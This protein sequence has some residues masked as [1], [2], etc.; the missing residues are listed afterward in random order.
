MLPSSLRQPLAHQRSLGPPQGVTPKGPRTFI[1]APAPPPCQITLDFLYPL[2]LPANCPIVAEMDSASQAEV[3]NNSESGSQR[4]FNK[5]HPPP[6]DFQDTSHNPSMR[7][8]YRDLVP[9]ISL[10][11]TWLSISEGDQRHLTNFIQGWD[12]SLDLLQGL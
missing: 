12:I 2:D 10:F 4:E 7:V 5:L 8:P 6:S 3:G 1:G 9:T 11:S